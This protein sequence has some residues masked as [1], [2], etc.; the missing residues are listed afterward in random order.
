M[1]LQ[2]IRNGQEQTIE[3]RDIVPGDIVVVEEGKINYHAL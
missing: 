2:V 1:L 3:A